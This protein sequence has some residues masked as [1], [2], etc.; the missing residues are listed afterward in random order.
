MSGA[1]SRNLGLGEENETQ[2]AIRPL[3]I[4]DRAHQGRILVQIGAK[5]LESECTNPTLYV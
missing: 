1:F 4:I 5:G 2:K 3:F